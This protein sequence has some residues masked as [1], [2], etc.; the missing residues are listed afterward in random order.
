MYDR[1]QCDW[2]YM[3]DRAVLKPTSIN[4]AMAGKR[5]VPRHDP[6][7]PKDFDVTS[8]NSSSIS[9]T[10]DCPENLKYSLFLLTTF[11]LNGTDHI[12]EEVRLWLTED[13]FVFTLSDLQPC[14]RIKFGLQTVCQ[15]GMESR[16]SKMVPNDGN[17]VHSR[18]WALRQTSFGPDNYT[19]RWEVKNTSSI[20]KFRVYHDGE[21]HGT[22]LMTNYTIGGLLSCQQYPA[23]VEALC[24]DDVLMSAKTVTAHTGPQGVSELRYR[25]NDSTAQWTPSTSQQSALAFLYELS[26]E[27]GTAIQS[28]RVTDTELRLPGLDEG[29][30]YILDVW[31]ECDGEWA[32]EPSQL[33]FAGANSSLGFIMRAGGPAHDLEL[34]FDFSSMGLTMVVPW[35]LP[36]DLQD[37][38]RTKMGKIFK[39]KLQELLK[40]FDQ[41]ARV[42][43]ATF[44]LAEDP[45]KTEI[46]FMSFDAS[47]TEEDVPL[48]VEDQLDYIR[49]MN[50]TYITVTDGVIHWNGHDM[51]ASFKHTVCPRNSLCINTLGSF[52]CVCQHG[53]YDVSLVIEPR[54]ASNPICNDLQQPTAHQEVGDPDAQEAE[55][56]CCSVCWTSGGQQ[57]SEGRS[58]TILLDRAHDND[59]HCGWIS[60]LFGHNCTFIECNEGNHDLL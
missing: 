6:D 19:M 18:I 13:S 36:E 53:H 50:A 22:T 26:S 33:C 47:K 12:T 38:P 41:P 2:S 23:M 35:S 8:W 56:C 49:Y 3:C 17:S 30:T 45:D 46:L 29:K 10:W 24:G 52:T 57:E 40:D 25:S 21:L 59:L 54:L 44:E 60:G 55:T 11:Y 34:Q 16:Y 7:I 5:P 4:R 42:E 39:D 37:E 48:P 51:C 31:E 20:S 43:L 32:S 9:L 15:S 28:S 58:P 27:N 14:S 1:R